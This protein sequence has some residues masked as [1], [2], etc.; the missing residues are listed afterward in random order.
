MS[1]SDSGYLNRLDRQIYSLRPKQTEESRRSGDSV[2]LISAA[3]RLLNMTNKRLDQVEGDILT[4]LDF[5]NIY[6]RTVS[7]PGDLEKGE[8]PLLQGWS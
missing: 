3:L 8:Y 7:L 5:N 1:K 2:L 4:C 6:Y